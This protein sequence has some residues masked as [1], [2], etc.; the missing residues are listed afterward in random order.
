MAKVPSWMM[1]II[2]LLEIISIAAM[3]FF[4]ATKMMEQNEI[5]FKE[6]RQMVLNAFYNGSWIFKS[7][8]TLFA[9]ED[10]IASENLIEFYK[11]GWI[12]FPGELRSSTG[13]WKYK[14]TCWYNTKT[15]DTYI[16]IKE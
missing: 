16:Q 15:D 9:D 10:A 5:V 3:I 14:V 13:P 12:C 4:G 6:R 11:N 8:Y 7:N 2:I 1:K